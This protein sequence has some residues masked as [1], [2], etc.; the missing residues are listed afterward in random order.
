MTRDP[1]RPEL[2][3]I[4]YDYTELRATLAFR[5]FI[6]LSAGYSP[7]YSTYSSRGIA[8]SE[9][10]LG[11]EAAAHFPATRYLTLSA[12]AGY[13]N[14]ESLIGSSYWYWSAGAGGRCGRGRSS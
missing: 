10:A 1:F 6:E 8:E 3:D 4:D 7:D 2:S 9:T 13:R 14:L 5:D 11:Y 12:G